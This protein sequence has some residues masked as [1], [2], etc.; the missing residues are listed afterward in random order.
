MR[1]QKA[2]T[3]DDEDL[4]DLVSRDTLSET[5]SAMDESFESKNQNNEDFLCN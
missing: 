3:E 5:G 2:G 4:E 1:Y